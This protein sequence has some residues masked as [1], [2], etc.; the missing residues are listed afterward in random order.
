MDIR[1]ADSKGRLTG[2]EPGRYYTLERQYNG[3]I[4]AW[5][6]FPDQGSVNDYTVGD[7]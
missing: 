5:A 4:V 7:E 3:A 1:K 2:F 6:A